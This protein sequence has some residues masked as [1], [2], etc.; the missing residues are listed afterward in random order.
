[1]VEYFEIFFLKL[2]SLICMSSKGHQY[3]LHILIFFCPYVKYTWSNVVKSCDLASKFPSSCYSRGIF[4]SETF[5][6]TPTVISEYEELSRE[7]SIWACVTNISC[8]RSEA[9]ELYTW[10]HSWQ[11][12][13]HVNFLV[14]NLFANFIWR[15]PR[16]CKNH[17]P[18]CC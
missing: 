17:F 1:V 15:L 10:K 11:S 7:N 14:R 2:F 4:N 9:T 16:L 18:F 6:S 3:S 8:R 5:T 12:T 13:A